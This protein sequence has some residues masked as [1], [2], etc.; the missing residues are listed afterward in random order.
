MI[1]GSNLYAYCLNNPVNYIDPLGL[2]TLEK[3]RSWVENIQLY[4]IE[5]GA[6]MEKGYMTNMQGILGTI[7]VSAGAYSNVGLIPKGIG[8]SNKSLVE[9]GRVVYRWANQ[10]GKGIKFYSWQ[11]VGAMGSTLAIISAG[12]FGWTLG[13]TINAYYWGYQNYKENYSK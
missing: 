8:Y 4:L 1:N 10:Y 11:Q 3:D 12:M 13:E 9:G 5:V 7:G 2:C 6:E